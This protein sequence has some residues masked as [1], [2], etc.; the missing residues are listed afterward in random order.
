MECADRILINSNMIRM[1]IASSFIERNENLRTKL[2]NDR[3]QLA[4]YLGGS[5][6]NKRLRVMIL[7]TT[8]HAGIAISQE[9]E[10]IYMQDLSSSTCLFLPYL[11]Q[12]CGRC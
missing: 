7:S 1:P 10:L 5:G 12:V 4:N 2:A 9:P 6:M 8:R 3:H 11:P